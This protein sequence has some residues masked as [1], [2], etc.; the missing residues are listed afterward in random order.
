V[1]ITS[2]KKEK[3]Q[4]LTQPIRKIKN[5]LG[6]DIRQ[7]PENLTQVLSLCLRVLVVKKGNKMK[8][9]KK[10]I[11]EKCYLSPIS[12]ED[13]EQY[14][15]W[16]NDL[17]VTKNLLM[18]SQQITLEKEREILSDMSKNRSQ[19]FGIIDKATDKLI[20]NCSLFRINN[21]NRKA[22]FGIFI[23]DRK[24]WNKGFGTEATKLILDYGFNIL[25]LN[26][27][28][29]EVFSFNKRAIK[30]YEKVGF[31]MIGKRR[32]AIIFGENKYDEI[33]MDIL[34]KGFESVYIEKI[35]RE[36]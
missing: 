24:Y 12:I 11:G 34:A 16:I 29:L 14:V 18:S 36:D 20:G 17:E 32:E 25:N 7:L 5:N 10:L 9:Y 13:A 4:D 3:F 23:G 1:F 2:K 19:V 31:K 35:M 21:L 28:M 6:K 22:E 27:I 30:S 26:N 15:E 33:Y 8:Y